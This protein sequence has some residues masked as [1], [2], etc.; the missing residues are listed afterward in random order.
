MVDGTDFWIC[1]LKP[2]AK[3][4]Y[5]HKFVKA[6]LCYEVGLC[7]QTGLIVWINGPFAVGKYNNITIFRSKM[8]YELLDWEMVE[9]DQCYVGQPNKICM[10]YELGVSEN[11]FEAKARARARARGEMINGRFKNF[12][13]LMDRYRHKI[14]MHSY[15][16]YAVVVLMQISLTTVS[17]TFKVDYPAHDNF[18]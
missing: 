16:F 5:S 2:F 7:I 1:E 10:K 18:Y 4:F 9:A 12:C 11:Q 6:G 15:V 14:S 13:R 17:P 8:I 3:A